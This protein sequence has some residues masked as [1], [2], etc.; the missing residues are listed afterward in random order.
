V[1]GRKNRVIRRAAQRTE[2][3]RTAPTGPPPAGGDVATAAQARRIDRHDHNEVAHYSDIGLV[4]CIGRH[5]HP[6]A[7]E[8]VYRRHGGSIHDLTAR[9]CGPTEARKVVQEVLLELWRQPST[10]DPDRGSLRSFLL[11]R[12]HARA[13]DLARASR[14]SGVSPWYP[15]T[16]C[17][18]DA[19]VETSTGVDA[20]AAQLLSDL[21]DDE[22][23]A[24]LLAYLDGHSYPEIA[25]VLDQP[26][27]HV[28]RVIRT[29]LED[30][31][32]RSCE[33]RRHAGMTNGA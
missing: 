15:E 21:T 26:S 14:R 2:R 12:A 1:K 29:G 6:A 25:A 5:R 24:I 33:H 31:R 20:H 3:D 28:A 9:V 23:E 13:A 17:R 4:I 32:I 22:R 7:L 19:G 11:S 10:F 16:A 30:L 18:D 27:P 8:E